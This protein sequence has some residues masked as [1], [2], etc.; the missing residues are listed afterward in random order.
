MEEFCESGD[1]FHGQKGRIVGAKRNIF[2][3]EK[4]N[5]DS[6]YADFD[7][8]RIENDKQIIIIRP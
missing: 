1:R 5:N 4:S 3:Q 7:W 2:A 6:G 8:F